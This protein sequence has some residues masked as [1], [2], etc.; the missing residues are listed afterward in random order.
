MKVKNLI[1]ITIIVI[2]FL[3]TGCNKEPV[4]PVTELP[5]DGS[6]K[7]IRVEENGIGIEFCLLNEQGEP[8]TVF[9]E[10]ENFKFHLGIVNN[11]KE[12]DSLYLVTDFLGNPGLF[13]VYKE[14]N[15]TVGKPVKW[16]GMNEI[17]DGYPIFNGKE[18]KIEFPWHEE[19]GSA[20]PYDYET[21]IHIF[22]HYFM[23][24]AQPYLPTGKYYT[25]FTQHFCLGSYVNRPNNEYFCTDTLQLKIH[26][27]IE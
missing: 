26:F 27:E 3:L 17:S 14:N 21:H 19:R 1:Y 15:D 8:A 4:E 6:Q 7:V 18:W 25:A 12:Y 2:P 9:K 13:M 24:L 22:Q 23:G 16:E 5:A 10:G 20:K 11:V